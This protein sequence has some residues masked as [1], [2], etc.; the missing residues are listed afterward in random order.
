MYS[1]WVRPGDLVFDIGAHL[2]DR[3]IAFAGL[4]AR[5]VALEPQPVLF[6]WLSRIAGGRDSVELLELAAGESPQTATLAISRA[7]PSVST[8]S[9]SWRRKISRDNPGF[10]SVSWD[11][12]VEVAVT[13]LD[14][15][16]DQFGQPVFCKI[17]VEGYE[18][19]VLAGLSRPLDT[20]SVE[21][22]AGALDVA[23]S[24]VDRLVQLGDYRFNAI[25]GEKRTLLWS[26]WREADEIRNWFADGADG[27]NSGDL[28]ARLGRRKPNGAPQAP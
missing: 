27:L 26:Q 10:R 17:D 11:E 28:Y 5:V 20:V 22:V 7:T 8:L 3:T 14:E 12:T 25:P 2:G 13:T 1:Q 19:R 9:G 18:D 6:R 15:L 23:I 16:I 24:A 21:F 4:G